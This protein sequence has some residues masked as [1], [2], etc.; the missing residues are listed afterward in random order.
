MYTILRKTV[1]PSLV[2]NMDTE[3][4][5]MA[6]KMDAER[7][8]SELTSDDVIHIAAPAVITAGKYTHLIWY[9]I[10]FLGNILSAYI[11]NVKTMYGVCSSAHY[12]VAISICDILCQTLHIFYYLT[13]YWRLTV[14]ITPG[15]CEGWGVLYTIPL[16]I[17]ELLVLGFIIE[18][19]ISLQNPLG[20]GW[21]KRNRRAPKEIVWT[22]VSVTA[23]C[24]FQ[25]YFRR[26][27]IKTGC[28][29]EAFSE[30][31][32]HP[33]WIWVPDIFIYFVVPV[34]VVILN[35][36]ILHMSKRRY[37]LSIPRH[38]LHK[39]AHVRV[40]GTL[41]RS[42]VVLLRLSFFRV[43]T[44]FPM[45]VADF[46][47][48]FDPFKRSLLPSVY[49]MDDVW[50]SERWHDY[51]FYSIIYYIVEIISSSRYA[52]SVFIYVTSSV[53][54]RRELRKLYWRIKHSLTSLFDTKISCSRTTFVS[55]SDLTRNDN[56]VYVV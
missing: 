52:L 1:A 51:L 54:F 36:C 30:E 25:A 7:N 34:S 4:I 45:S 48:H 41:K 14:F 43:I 39:E 56:A 16:Y 27:D 17:S 19:L 20:S 3:T 10:G 42:T 23:F 21:F 26:V 38:P 5:T 11:W 33:V 2:F 8:A 9:G 46:L 35:F 28:S 31:F 47:K 15:L 13:M 44:L 40:R 55:V 22:I 37:N 49:S 50:T 12:L 53:H 18:K 6:F 32:V 29:N 24:V